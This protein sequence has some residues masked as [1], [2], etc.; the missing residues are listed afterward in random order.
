MSKFIQYNQYD[1][2]INVNE[3]KKVI[4][5][6]SKDECYLIL[7]DGTN[8]KYE[9]KGNVLDQLEEVNKIIQIIEPKEQFYNVYLDDDIEVD[10]DDVYVAYPVEYL[11]LTNNG[12]I[13]GIELDK[14][15]GYIFSTYLASNYRHTTN[16]KGLEWFIEV[17]GQ[18]V[19]Y[20]DDNGDMKK[21]HKGDDLL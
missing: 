9:L 16:K 20:L 5:S 7:K 19:Y 4:N 13:V 2:F 14:Y 1:S 10:R 12:E 18:E 15:D 3:I 8:L 11:G 17:G 6:H 21:W